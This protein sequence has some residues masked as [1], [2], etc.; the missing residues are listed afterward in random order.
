MEN[1]PVIH[2]FLHQSCDWS[3]V[4]KVQDWACSLILEPLPSLVVPE[5]AG[6][7]LGGLKFA[8][9]LVVLNTL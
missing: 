6:A 8:V 1:N 4:F 5:E 9:I 3:L 7:F 2:L